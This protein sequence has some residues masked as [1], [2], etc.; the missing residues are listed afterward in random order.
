[1]TKVDLHLHSKYSDYAG[2]WLLKAY[3][4]PESFT[5]PETLYQQAKS[6]G[7]DLVTITDH[8]DIRGCLEL[9]KSHPYD[10]FISCEVTAY[11]PEDGC[12]AHILV[13]G[14]NEDQY[15]HLMSVRRNI[16]TLRDYISE[17]N[18]ACSV[19]HATHDQDGKL[20]F[21]HIEKLILLFNVF[22]IINGGSSALSNNLLHVY[23]K[24]LNET[25]INALK[26]KH[27]IKPIGDNPW[28][29][30]YTG[31]SD[32]HC[33]LLIGTA[34]TQTKVDNTN[35]LKGTHS[36][37]DF[38]D[39]IQNKQTIADGLNGSFE[40]YAT[41]VFKHIHDYRSARDSKYKKT[42]MSDFLEMFFSGD[43]GNWTKRFKKRQSLR[44]LKRKNSKTH[45]ALHSL[46]KQV[47]DET[48][49]DI[50]EKIPNTFDNIALLHD[51][52]FR[53]VISAFTKHIPSGD[54]FKAFN[55]LATAFPMTL[56]A[57]PFVGSMRHQ[58]LKSHIKESLTTGSN[59]E[60]TEKALWFTDTIDDLNGVS[61]T[62]RQIAIYS[63][64]HNYNL[65]I[66]T[67]V[68]EATINTPLPENTINFDPVK[69]ISV[70]GYETQEIGFP[71]MLSMMK[72]IATEQPDQIII[73]TPGPLGLGA[74]LCAKLM[75]LP[76]K[77]IYHTDFSEQ[78]YRMTGEKNLAEITDLFV[79]S[80]YKLADKVFV[81]SKAYISKLTTA[82]LDANKMAIF[83]RGL[84]LDL[85]RP[86]V[87]TDQ[88]LIGASTLSGNFTLMFAGRLS[89][90][91]NLSLLIKIYEHLQQTH[92]DKFNLIIA[93][94]GPAYADLNEKL[95]LYQN[96]L[97]TG[98][99]DAAELVK[100][101]Q[102]SDLF[103][104][105]SHTDTFGMVILEAQA[106]GVPALVTSSGGP[107]EII[108][109]QQTGRII[110]T[111]LVD[112]WMKQ[113]HYYH[114]LK[115]SNL[116][117]FQT[118]QQHC[119]E[120]V[121]RQNNWQPVFDQVLGTKCSIRSNANVDDKS[122]SFNTSEIA[123]NASSARNIAA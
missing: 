117:E 94:D 113:I 40:I 107:Q 81:P 70:P 34:F 89:E 8:D 62:L 52:M 24:R 106:C 29:K 1:M 112:D 49:K 5:E 37:S 35:S 90:D 28:I 77:M 101:Y 84:N 21:E 12:K 109:D 102:A 30:G 25:K 58:V 51:E 16:Y 9:V 99:I 14:I 105:P 41:S 100:C 31:G 65:K 48:Q 76:V 120:H 7:M 42:K 75:D 69:S 79:N 92:P 97:F 4:S 91:K 86:K 115:N 88:P 71:S 50:A 44:Y 108:I 22:E 61:V 20:T 57:S 116:I 72:R 33:G 85:Y 66:V 47:S 83:P 80:T 82:G 46:L 121:H 118:V 56:L 19:A 45:R 10:C 96:V 3:D 110:E 114:D 78:L 27:N 26:E 63:Q 39:A 32:D 53:S 68:D 23:L 123:P 11:F 17:Q 104:F 18:I 73:S 64:K 93:G 54:I 15:G 122:L 87:K 2:T 95:D 98:R 59:L 36:I 67:S 6:R 119:S 103:V 55:H 38:L 111:D 60:Y 43:E 74:I 13:Y